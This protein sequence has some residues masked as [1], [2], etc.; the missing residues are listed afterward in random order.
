M[1]NHLCPLG[2]RTA[3]PA[4]QAADRLAQHYGRPAE[5]IGRAPGRLELLG[6][7]TDYNEGLVTAIAIEQATAVAAAR[8]DD[9]LIRVWTAWND[10]EADFDLR[11]LDEGPWGQWWD[12]VAGVCAELAAEGCGPPGAD[13]AIVSEVPVAGGVS[14][15]AALEVACAVVLS[16]LRG[17]A[18][19]P[20]RLALLC[21]RAENEFVG[22]RCGILDQFT[23]V[24]GRPDS[25][26]WLDCRTRERRLVP[27]ADASVR[28]VVCDTRTPRELVGSAYNERRAQCE[29]AARIL[30]VAALRD[31]DSATLRARA[32][33]LDE[34]LLRRARHVVSENERVHKGVAAL[35]SGDWVALGRLINASHVSLRDD[36]EVSSA[37]LEIMREAAL[38]APGCIGARLVGAGFG[39]CVMALVE[40]PSVDLFVAQVAQRYQQASGIRP[41]IFATGAADGAGLVPLS[42]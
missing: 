37:A 17:C 32:G 22:M 12:Y 13:L 6:A 8:R 33:E 27:M 10:S 21:Q 18:V 29:R 42:D 26:L 5:L 16:S 3:R 15:S 9:A 31:L 11:R 23:A 24:F 25:V 35:R 39:G 34:T 28:F 36:Y 4:W 19:D 30:G 20:E 1:Y 2:P 40:A 14:S 41:S 38:Q 7:H